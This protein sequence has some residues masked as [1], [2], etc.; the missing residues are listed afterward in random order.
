M[1]GN[2]RQT[3]GNLREFLTIGE[4]AEFLGVSPGTL[5]NWDRA[6]QLHAVRHPINRYRLYRR[7]ELEQF[8]RR[9]KPHGRKVT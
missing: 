7:L 5:R 9:L 6:G 2:E 4:A 8:L 3:L 1:F